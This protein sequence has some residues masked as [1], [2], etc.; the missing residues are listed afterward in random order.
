MKSLFSHIAPRVR[1]WKERSPELKNLI[2]ITR[3]DE[4]DSLSSLFTHFIYYDFLSCV[5]T[6]LLYLPQKTLSNC[7]IFSDTSPSFCGGHLDIPTFHSPTNRWCINNPTF[8]IDSPTKPILATF[9]HTNRWSYSTVGLSI[10][11]SRP[12]YRKSYC[13]QDYQYTSR[14]Q[15]IVSPIL[16][17]IIDTLVKTSV[18]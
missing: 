9:G 16:C 2:T 17:R 18:L 5:T 13:L 6:H 4:H 3:L 11:W 12:V 15:Y 14:G 7:R 1:S 8:R 10:R